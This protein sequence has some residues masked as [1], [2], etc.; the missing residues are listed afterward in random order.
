MTISSKKKVPLNG[1][2]INVSISDF[3]VEVINRKEKSAV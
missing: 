2:Y 1:G 3:V